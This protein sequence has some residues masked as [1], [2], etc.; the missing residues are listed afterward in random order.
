M[1]IAVFGLK[2]PQ[3]LLEILRLISIPHLSLETQRQI[4]EKLDRQIQAMEGV[5]LLKSEAQKRIE[6]ILAEVWGEK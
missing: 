3:A 1:I 4:V 2:I 6:E 5:R